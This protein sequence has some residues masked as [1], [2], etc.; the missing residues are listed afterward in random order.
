MPNSKSAEKRLRTSEKAR[1]RN[2]MR[3]S[4]MKTARQTFETCLADGDLDAARKALDHC[5]AVLDIAAKVHAIH[6]NTA[7]RTKSRLAKQLHGATG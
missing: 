1:L 4:H 7:S 6:R 3:R 5:F 2:K